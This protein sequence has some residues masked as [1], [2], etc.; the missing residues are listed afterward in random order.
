MTKNSKGTTRTITTL[1]AVGLM[2]VVPLRRAHAGHV[3]ETTVAPVTI[4]NQ[5]GS[6]SG[7]INALATK[8]QIDTQNDSTKYVQFGTPPGSSYQG[9]FTY[10]LPPTVNPAQI[11]T[12]TFLANVLGPSARSDAFTWSIYNWTT[13]KY[14][15]LG[16]QNVCGGTTGTHPCNSSTN[17]TLDSANY[18]RWK[19]LQRM[20]LGRP[21]TQYVN[22]SGQ[23]QVQLASQNATGY[24]DVDYA[25]MDVFTNDGIAGTLWI[26][27]QNY[28][29]QYQLQ[30]SSTGASQYASTEGINVN[31][32]V[33][34][35]H[36]RRL[37]NS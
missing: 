24:L 21:L 7:S 26:P 25:V 35:L 19:W 28:R 36:W 22:A 16:N 9:Y 34:L 4:T 11:T 30:V 15:S 29:W 2:T 3:T 20:A 17:G 5:V 12:L 27:P 33:V 37:C 32:C 10:S 13:S 14:E 6:Y 18:A 1:I 31:I 8:D 23:I